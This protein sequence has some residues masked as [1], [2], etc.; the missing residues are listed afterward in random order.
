M[1]GKILVSRRNT[2]KATDLSL[3]MVDYLIANGVL[4]AV[5]VGTRTLVLKSSIQKLARVGAPGKP[6]EKSR[7]PEI[8][9]NEGGRNAVKRNCEF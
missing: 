1:N 2:K 8:L 7:T 5:K 6:K 3:R 4:K 9:G